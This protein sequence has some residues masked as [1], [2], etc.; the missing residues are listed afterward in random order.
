MHTMLS[1]AHNKQIIIQ[2]FFKKGNLVIC[3]NMDPESVILSE[4]RRER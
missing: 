2:P 4:K 3:Y 1:V